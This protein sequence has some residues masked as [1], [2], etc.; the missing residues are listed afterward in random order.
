MQFDATLKAML[1]AGPQDWPRLLGAPADRVEVI[2]ADT[3][4][5]SGAADKVLRVHGESDWILHLE[6]QAGPDAG[7]PG[8]LNVYNAILEDRTGLPVRT[9]CILLRPAA[10]LRA[11]T[12]AYERH[13]PGA[14]GPYRRFEYDVVRVWEL[15]PDRLLAG[16]GTLPLAPIGAV[17]EAE[18]PRVL[19]EMKARIGKRVRKSLADQLWTSTYVLMGLR[20]QEAVTSRLFEEVLGMEESTTYQ[21]I[22]RKGK[23]AGAIEQAQKMILRQGELRFGLVPN[24]KALKAL[25]AI[26]DVE[27]LERLGERLLTIETWE[28]LLGLPEPRRGR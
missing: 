15:P 12:G 23:I 5:V 11:Y 26:Q 6:F 28:E 3:S 9:A 8:K 19:R 7:K 21:A 27:T 18:V 17:S 10:S 25:M 22:I 24:K 20:Y 13:W 14:G 4:T 16:V 2:D 1:E